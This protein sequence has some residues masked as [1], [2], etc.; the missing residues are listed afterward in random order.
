MSL[1]LRSIHTTKAPRPQA[2]RQMMALAPSLNLPDGRRVVPQHYFVYQQT[3]A[4]VSALIAE[5]DLDQHSLLFCHEDQHGIYVQIGMIGRENYEDG[6]QIRPRKLVYGR[7]WRIDADM[8]DS[9]IV[10]T[11]ML[12]LK[13]AREH[14]VRELFQVRPSGMQRYSA[15]LSSHQDIEILSMQSEFLKSSKVETDA[16]EVEL[17]IAQRLATMRFAQ[18][19]LRLV[20]ID[21]LQS[22]SLVLQIA[23]GETSLARMQ[24]GDFPEFAG[25][26]FEIVLAA[27]RLHELAYEILEAAIKLSDRYVEEHFQYRGFARFS[28]QHAVEQI[29]RLSLISR[30]YAKDMKDAR[31][32]QIFRSTNYQTDAGRKAR[33]GSGAL[34]HKNRAKIRRYGQLTGHMPADL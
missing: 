28:R 21:R 13:K 33:L 11:A 30:P 7:K 5:I 27:N 19:P 14:E 3:L 15:P 1:A 4:S 34:A 18:R 2:S 29:A 9:E 24:E 32:E 12:A 6:N 26:Q 10:A 22:G 16:E 20:S 23:L 25:L 8:P 17:P 31:F